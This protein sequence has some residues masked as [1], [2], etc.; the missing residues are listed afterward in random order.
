MGSAGDGLASTGG[1]LLD[2]LTRIRKALRD[3]GRLLL[4]E[5][6]HRGFLSRSLDMSLRDFQGKMREA[7]FVI[8]HVEPMHFWPIRLFLANW[9]VPHGS[10]DVCM[11][12]ARE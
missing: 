10:L 6:I 1:Q 7:G 5:P 4:L 3:D 9:Q 12:L 11:A 8:L 2:A